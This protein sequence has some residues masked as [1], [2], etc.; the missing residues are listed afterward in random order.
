MMTK[1]KCTLG[2]GRHVCE[3]CC[4]CLFH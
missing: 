4:V 3:S 1:T 2:C